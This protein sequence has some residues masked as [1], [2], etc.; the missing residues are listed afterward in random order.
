MQRV[1]RR[2]Q[3]CEC[4]QWRIVGYDVLLAM[5]T[6]AHWTCARLRSDIFTVFPLRVWPAL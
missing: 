4:G 2:I 5:A 3:C 1:V 6:D